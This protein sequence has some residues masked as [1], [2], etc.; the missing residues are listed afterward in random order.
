MTA[1]VQPE[2]RLRRWT[3]EEYH[4]MAELGW[5]QD[6]RVE[7]IEGDIREMTPQN[8]AHSRAV[9]RVSYALERAFDR[10]RYWL[11]VQMPLVLS[12][13]TEPEPDV[14]V[15][16]GPENEHQRQPR[17]A[18]LVVEVSENTL[19]YDR[20]RKAA[21]YA[22]AGIADYWVLNLIDRQLEVHRQPVED[23]QAPFGWRYAEVRIV[24]PGETAAPLAAPSASLVVTD[25]LP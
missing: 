5:F 14:S 21:L 11:R 15:A 19:A 10:R 20:G 18:L 9:T 6:Q 1:A 22:R 2:P 17:S 24:K 23:A 7:L 4:R 13:V 25:L 8:L 16:A 3:R 12:E